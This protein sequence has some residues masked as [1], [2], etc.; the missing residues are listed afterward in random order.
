MPPPTRRRSVLR[1]NRFRQPRSCAY[2]YSRKALTAAVRGMLR[3]GPFDK[4][5]HSHR[6]DSRLTL[7]VAYEVDALAGGREHRV[8]HPR[9]AGA[10]LA[11]GQLAFYRADQQQHVRRSHIAAGAKEHAPVRV[12]RELAELARVGDQRVLIRIRHDFA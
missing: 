1:R 11:D 4:L 9:I 6:I 5:F 12:M 3:L 10:M 8:D 2:Y 7:L